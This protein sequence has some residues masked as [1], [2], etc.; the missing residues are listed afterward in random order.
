M[1]YTKIVKII[2]AVINFKKIN[3]TKTKF[4][5]ILGEAHENY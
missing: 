3:I 2:I 4:K 5:G 1:C